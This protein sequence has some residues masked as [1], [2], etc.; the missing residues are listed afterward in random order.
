MQFERSK[1]VDTIFI[2]YNMTLTDLLRAVKHYDLDAD[3]EVKALRLTQRK[4]KAEKLEALNKKLA[5]T[6][7]DHEL[8]G[9]GIK[10]VGTALDP[11]TRE[12]NLT[13]NSFQKLYLV[14]I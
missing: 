7:A 9:Q 11:P 6:P 5:L 3:D 1:V 2:K 12:G 8:I 4:A 10:Q 13:F 14:I